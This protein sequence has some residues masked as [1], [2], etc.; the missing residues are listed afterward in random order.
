MGNSIKKS[1][2]VSASVYPT[3]R[4]NA[5]HTRVSS[6][7]VPPYDLCKNM[8]FIGIFCDKDQEGILYLSLEHMHK[9]NEMA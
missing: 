6:G 7:R 5:E 1:Y 4:A 9:T 8:D 2:R 3:R